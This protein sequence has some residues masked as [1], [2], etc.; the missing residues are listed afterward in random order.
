[1]GY[2][3]SVIEER[4]ALEEQTA[5][6]AETAGAWSEQDHPKMR[7]EEDIDRWLQ[8]L[9]R[10]WSKQEAYALPHYV[11]DTG[12]VLRHLRGQRRAVKL[13]SGLGRSGR[14]AVSAITRLEVHAGMQ[15]E[16]KDFTR[17]LLLRFMTYDLDRE[18]ADRAGDLI[19]ENQSRHRSLSVPDAIIATTAVVHGLT[20]VTL[21]R[22]DF[23]DIPGLAV[24]PLPDELAS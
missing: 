19:G 3:V 7:S 10:S 4:L 17:K 11:I 14:L 12:L 22:T 2:I 21:N 5:V 20:L 23:G 9:R 18:L 16:E 24:K 1:L 15:P 13:L 8:N 6:L